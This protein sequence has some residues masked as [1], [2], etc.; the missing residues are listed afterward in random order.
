MRI[1]WV[2]LISCEV[3]I[4][5]DNIYEALSNVLPAIVGIG[6]VTLLATG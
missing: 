5:L 3:I 6:S 4:T 2:F 1:L